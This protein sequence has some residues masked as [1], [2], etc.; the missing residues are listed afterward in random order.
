MIKCN[1]D[2]IRVLQ[3]SQDWAQ[4]NPDTP[5]EL[6][7]AKFTKFRCSWISHLYEQKQVVLDSLE[8]NPRE[9]IPIILRRAQ[10]K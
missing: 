7:K 3:E 8:S 1:E 5:M 6:D 10:V 2:I 9:V 4:E